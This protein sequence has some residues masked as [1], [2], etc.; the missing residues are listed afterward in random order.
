LSDADRRSALVVTAGEAEPVVREWRL[1]YLRESVERG[2]PPHLTIL[3]PFVPE[4][5]IDDEVLT[6]LGR[7]YAPVSPFDYALES[8]ESFPDAAWLAPA[9]A[10]PFLDLI[11]RTRAAF[12]D[13]PPYGNSEYVPVPHCTLG[14]DD[15]PARVEAMVR[16]LRA[17]L[18]ARLP[19]PCRAEE[20][21]L[22]GERA[23][24]SWVERGA[25]PLQGRRW[26][27]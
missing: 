16:E 26:A 10:E 4:S 6:A 2:I 24:G 14:V 27:G 23:D 19:V 9:P 3:F 20:V 12:P 15:D 21:S 1:R 11:A 8:V 13:L 25:F 7:L 22:V 17:G 5:E 18:G